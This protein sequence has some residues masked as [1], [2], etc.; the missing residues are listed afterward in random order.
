[1]RARMSFRWKLFLTFLLLLF[2]A[3][4]PVYFWTESWLQ[5][6]YRSLVR[7]QLEDEVR[8]LLPLLELD[9]PALDSRLDQAAEQTRHRITVVDFTGR[10][11]SDSGFSGQALRA[12]DNHLQRPE[13]QQALHSGWGTSSRFSD[14]VKEELLYVAVLLPDKAGFLRFAAPLPQIQHAIGDLRRRLATPT[15]LLAALSLILAWFLSRRL[16]GKI[17]ILG[18]AAQRIA[19]GQF[20]EPIAVS[21]SDEIGLLASNMRSM[22]SQLDTQMGSLVAD[23]DHLDTVFH[24]MLEG[25]MVTDTNGRITGA[26]PA[27]TRLF[28]FEG[29]SVG[30]MP[31]E[32]FQNVGIHRG[33]EGVLRGESPLE[34]EVEFKE[35]FLLARFAPVVQSSGIT[36]AVVVFHDNTRRRRLERIRKDFVSNVSH[37]LKTPLTSIRGYS[38]TLLEETLKPVEQDFVERI[39]R[40]AQQLEAIVDDLLQL[41]LLESRELKL[42]LVPIDFE[43]LMA[44]L[45]RPFEETLRQQSLSITVNNRA[46]VETFLGA[47]A[48]IKRVLGNLLDNALKYTERGGIVIE[49]NWQ[50]SELQFAVKDSGVGIPKNDLE[51]VFERF[52]RVSTTRARDPRGTGLGLAIAKHVIQLHEGKIWLES[53]VNRGTTVYFTLP[54]EHSQS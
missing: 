22:A 27:F 15:L 5:A 40:N 7:S 12:M 18:E 41:S 45:R 6:Y 43:A 54:Q 50:G 21:G 23:R 20:S 13:I 51:R 35:R 39:H 33:V 25:V 11:L 44:E 24:A 48:F 34:I 46:A 1:M 9:D 8:L 10:V 52:Y 38:E 30:L 17:G 42:K 32:V 36:G 47:E 53:E 14:S 29:S 37:E 16:T 4:A 26:N 3:L 49:V 28:G 2:L 31:L 19:A